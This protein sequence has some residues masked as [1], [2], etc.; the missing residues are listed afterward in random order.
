MVKA[1]HLDHTECRLKEVLADPQDRQASSDWYLIRRVHGGV[2]D[3]FLILADWPRDIGLATA[4]E[5]VI[6]SNLSLLPDSSRGHS[7]EEKG[8]D[9][10]VTRQETVRGSRDAMN[11]FK[12]CLR[13][14]TPRQT[15][16]RA[17]TEM[18]LSQKRI[19]FLVLE[20]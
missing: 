17:E 3:P 1:L 19:R 15:R 20:F 12:K 11:L 6:P 7:T 13:Q 18:D 9:T 16:R 8:G 14:A 2:C 5:Q 10:K 4:H